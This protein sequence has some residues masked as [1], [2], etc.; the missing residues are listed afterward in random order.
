MKLAEVAVITFYFCVALSSVYFGYLALS[1]PPK[2]PCGVSEI[3]PDFSHA[4]REQCRQIRGHK[5]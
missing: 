1:Q 3:S 4:Q 2:L 5:L